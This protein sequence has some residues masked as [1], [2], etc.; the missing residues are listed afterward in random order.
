MDLT[1]LDTVSTADQLA[2]WLQDNLVSPVRPAISGPDFGVIIQKT[3]VVLGIGELPDLETTAKDTI[4]EAINELFNRAVTFVGITGQPTDNTALAS[5]LGGKVDKVTGY[6]LS[7][8]NYSTSEKTKLANLSEHFKG[9]YT[10]AAAL[11][12]ANPTGNAG[13]YG[14]VDAGAGADAKMYIW[15]ATDNDWV[16]SSGTGV[17]PD[18][19]ETNSGIIALATVAQALAGTDD[20]KAMTAL[21]TLDSILNQKKNVNY[22]IAPVSLNEVSFLMLNSGNVNS[23]TVSGA[24][25]V[26]LKIGISGTYPSGSQTFPF[27]YTA[28]DRVFATYTYTDLTNA[29]C[30][31][32][33]TCRDT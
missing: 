22:Q 18:A 7:Q 17:I 11:S 14:F 31:I 28:G 15:D 9:S 10:T 3:M 13:D 21:K 30:N 1:G 23:V 24:S 16:L 8:Q 2:T 25:N 5:A 26:K 19:T 33:L 6:G 20:A 12:A 29:S 4:V 27:P 32:I